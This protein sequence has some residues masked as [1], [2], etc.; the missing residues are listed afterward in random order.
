[1][2]M[3]G[4][5]GAILGAALG[6]ALWAGISYATGYEIGFVAWGV[7]GLVGGLAAWRGGRG[8]NMGMACAGLALLAILV[9]KLA[10][11][12]YGLKHELEKMTTDFFTRDLHAEIQED[13]RQFEQVG[14]SEQ[15][16]QFMVDRGYTD[17]TT[18]EAVQ[19]DEI[20][21]FEQNSV[22]ELRAF[23]ERTPPYREW[24]ESRSERFVEA[25][26]SEVSSID[27]V[28]ESLGFMD[29]IFV[30]LGVGTAFR[31]GEGGG[32]P[33]PPREPRNPTRIRPPGGDGPP[34]TDPRPEAP[35]PQDRP[36]APVRRRR[37]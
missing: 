3:H 10:A 29:I 2:S 37:H 20:E 1:M 31:L 36:D 33:R 7:G 13:A 21:G 34:P 23:Q 16:A 27:I 5:L 22:P 8:T 24:V 9:G 30:V 25:S 32:D 11:G 18:A 26:M 28:K 12:H 6:A 19:R 35:R 17:A 14:S 4:L 15:Y